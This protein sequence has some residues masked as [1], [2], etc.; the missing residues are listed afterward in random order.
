MKRMSH[1]R[2]F[3]A[4]AVLLAACGANPTPGSTPIPPTAPGV[5]APITTP[6]PDAPVLAA[7]AEQNARSAAALALPVPILTL[8]DGLTD[9]QQEAQRLAVAD[10]RFQRDLFD[11]QSGAPLRS[12]IFGIYPWRESDLTDSTAGCLN[13][14]ARCYRVEMYNYAYNAATLAT[15]DVVGGA[16]LAVQYLPDTQPDIPNYLV[17]LAVE[18][19]INS[20]EVIA[21]MGVQPEATDAM[22]P[23]A[24]TPLTRSRCE[25]SQHL[26]VAPTFL[27]GTRGLWAIVDLTDFRLVGV[28]WTDM[29]D[30]SASQPVTEKSLQDEVI[31][32]NYC[33]RTTPLDQAGW[34][35]DYMLTSSDGLRISNVRFN[36]VPVLDDAKVVDWHVAYSESD[37][38]GYSDAVGCPVFSQA[39]VVAARPPDIS[40][41]VVDGAE[42]GVS[43]RQDFWSPTWPA[44]CNYYYEQRFDFYSDGRFRVMVIS[45]GRGCGNDGVYRPVIR[46]AWAGEQGRFS[47]W[48]GTTWQGWDQEGYVLKGFESRATDEG[49]MFQLETEH[50]GY[51]IEPAFGQFD[52]GGRGD[53]PYVFVTRA[54]PDGE[55][56]GTDLPTIGPCCNTDYRQGPE[57]FIEPQPEN[58]SDGAPLVFWYVP[59]IEN[60]DTPGEEYCWAQ[61]VVVDGVFRVNEYPCVAGPMFVPVTAAP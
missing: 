27:A 30:P 33:D 57:K 10:P 23:N 47:E 9:E 2:I 25:R 41:I 6:D 21:A 14:P 5:L 4:L 29:G 15:V 3:L 31:T 51:F 42:V 7:I 22:M 1:L 34:S 11:T 55:E 50:S 40:P 28:R 37:G 48:T 17:R 24:K 49:F 46:M 56:G 16:V 13:G 52:D 58:L 32:A 12:E 20:P 61:S 43:L 54:K 38:F 36:D 44:P 26:C 39:A 59:Q 53:N 45:H 35:L 8:D 19:A 18:I 60:D